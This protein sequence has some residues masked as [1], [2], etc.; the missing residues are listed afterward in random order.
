MKKYILNRLKEKFEVTDEEEQEGFP[1]M[2]YQVGNTSGLDVGNIPTPVARRIGSQAQIGGGIME[3]QIY[4]PATFSVEGDQVISVIDQ[5]G[6]DITLHSDPNMGFSSSYKTRGQQGVGVETVHPYFTNYLDELA[7]FK[8]KAESEA[9][10]DIGRI[11]PHA[12]TSPLPPLEERMAADVGLDPFGYTLTEL[13]KQNWEKRSE[14]GR[15]IYKNKE[16]MEKFYHT[17]IKKRTI[18]EK[19]RLF[20]GRQG[21]FTNYSDKCDRIF[22]DAQRRACDSFYQEA[23]RRAENADDGDLLQTRIALVSTASTRDAG[24]ENR[25]LKR[26]ESEFED[27][28]PIY[29]EPVNDTAKN[30]LEANGL[31]EINKISDLNNLLPPNTRVTN[32]RTLNEAAYR[33]RNGDFSIRGM[34]EQDF[35]GLN[36]MIENP[37]DIIGEIR[38]L[39]EDEIND[40]LHTL[41]KGPKDNNFLISVESKRTAITN[42]L[43]VDQQRIFEEAMHY[44]GEDFQ[45]DDPEEMALDEAAVKVL[46]KEEG[47]FEE[48][49]ESNNGEDDPHQKMMRA[50]TGN[51]EQLIWQESNIFYFIMP[52]W[53]T[54]AGQKSDEHTGWKAPEFIWKALVEDKW[55]EKY[56]IDLKNP[57]K[58]NG[59]FDALEEST[60][61]RMDVAA[62]VG[63]CYIWGHFTQM[64][65]EF[66]S[67]KTTWI[68]FM[69]QHGIGVNLEAMHGSPQ[70]MLKLWRPK[71]IAVAAHAINITARNEL[72]EIHDE[73][74]E[75]IAKFTID[76][77]H[78]ASFGVNPWEEMEKLEENESRIAEYE[79]Y[80]T[81][82][83]PDKPLAKILRQYHLMKPGLESQQGTRHGP[84]S[85]GDKQLYT[86]LYRLVEKGFCRNPEEAAAIMY[87]QGE[88]K[89]ETIYTARIAMNMIELGIE[90][91]EVST[92]NI[93]LKRVE[94]NDYRDER[95]AL[96]ARFFGLDST[97]YSREWAKIE[98]HAFDP[99]EGLLEAEEFDYTYSS[100]AAMENENN[101]RD[102]AG[103]EYK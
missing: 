91:D 17:F 96:I 65:S 51:F 16:F 31:L 97:N 35:N 45:E 92:D 55:S 68:D 84:F 39:A 63:S 28:D 4:N 32:L 9:D 18:D 80:N 10:F 22:R 57:N 23:I 94:N 93:D 60:E 40:H 20:L 15:N 33:I 75:C 70:Q 79:D 26:I 102:Y 3:V 41:W 29:L 2:N 5:L 78:V 30:L 88:E 53:M 49:E 27:R 19:W 48:R 99:L 100:K 77:E 69:N 14:L 61:F 83:D 21:V 50:L 67:G 66:D 89:D 87:E 56:E 103:E 13:E 12:S 73:L 46:Q 54:C 24:V 64:D 85:R 43:D 95:E 76:M 8:Q 58:D 47:F 44:P 59:Y 37:E 1:D 72:E 25:W 38:E 11:N 52:A 6:L 71:D 36:E 7:D 34:R 101:P 62:A 98:E 74:D 42:H 90:P 81:G 86:W 82:I